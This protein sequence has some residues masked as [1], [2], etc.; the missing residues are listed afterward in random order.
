VFIPTFIAQLHNRRVP[1]GL[2]LVQ[3]DDPEAVGVVE[4][5]IFAV[6]LVGADND[7]RFADVVTRL[8][9]LTR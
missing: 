8:A 7:Q 6:R 2:Q 1:R 9:Q 4:R 5:T 3:R